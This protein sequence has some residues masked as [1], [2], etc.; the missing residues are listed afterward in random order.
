MRTRVKIC[1]ITRVADGLAAARLGAD[2]IGL[3]FYAASPRHVTAEQARAI[4]GALPPFV[5]R[6]GLFVDATADQVRA[7]VD[8]VGLDVLQFHG[9][10]PADT[11]GAFA[12]PYIKAVRMAAGIDLHAQ[13]SSYPGAAALLLDAHVEHLPGGSGTTFDWGRVPRDL[14]KP[15]I[16]AGGL[17]PANVNDAIVQVRPFAV[18]VSGG[19]EKAPGI[20][21]ESKIS[22]FM[23]CVRESQQ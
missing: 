9:N 14:E 21:D 2:A 11:C 7:T 20:K 8:A 19:V 16:L 22:E 15:L 4:S 3:V 18:D 6:V 1:G 17:T 12:R 5:T 23:R 13:Q 10:E